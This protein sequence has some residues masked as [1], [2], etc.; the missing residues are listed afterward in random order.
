MERKKKQFWALIFIWISIELKWLD[1]VQEMEMT[2]FE[3]FNLQET[4]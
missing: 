1:E 4:H 3:I 2:L